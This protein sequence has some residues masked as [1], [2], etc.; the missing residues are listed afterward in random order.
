MLVLFGSQWFSAE[1]E[2]FHFQI[3]G[4]TRSGK[5]REFALYL[6][7]VISQIIPGSDQETY[8]L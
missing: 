7:S 1:E 2:K 3:S 4:T 6:R 8:P 5:S